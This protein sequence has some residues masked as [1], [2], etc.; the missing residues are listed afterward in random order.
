VNRPNSLRARTAVF[1]AA[2]F[3][4]LLSLFALGSYFAIEHALLSRADNEARDQ[5]QAIL[6]TLEHIPATDTAQIVAQ[7]RSIGEARLELAIYA[8]SGDS[9]RLVWSDHMIPLLSL[10]DQSELLKGQSN[11]INIKRE[12]RTY[13]ALS[14]STG[15]HVAIATLDLE[16]IR[17][18]E[19]A[20]LRTF[21]VLLLIGIAG[22]AAL[23]YF[24]AGLSLAPI[25]LLIKGA[26]QLEVAGSS[27]V[28]AP[29]LPVPHHVTEVAVLANAVNRLIAERDS[30]ITKLKTFT[31][32]AAHEL[33]T[34]LTVLKG[35]LE[36]ELR[37]VS[38]E[39][40]S[41]LIYQSNLEEVER[42]IM[43]V[44]DLLL[45]ADLDQAATREAPIVDVSLALQRVLDRLHP[46]AEIKSVK[47]SAKS[48]PGLS[49]NAE[50][51]RLERMIYNLVHNAIA[52]SEAG[53]VVRVELRSRAGHP[54]LIIEDSGQGIAES[55]LPYIFDRFYRTERAR[56]RRYGGVGLGL[57]I[58]RSIADEYGF[59]IEINSALGE[60]TIVKVTL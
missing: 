22:S 54:N 46:L 17:E 26:R 53:G 21:V 29:L 14:V 32:D 8:R 51:E 49:T 56:N 4:L 3:T 11:P 43:I 36:V 60:G 52:Y 19:D 38:K 33:R 12:G 39:E 35:E 16:V 31:A 28:A 15:E 27:G 34:P 57:A 47:L 45:L 37:L 2:T 59:G 44:Q 23:G 41:Y 9:S 10:Q 42:L 1:I 18:A 6:L 48:E 7:H 58:V 13:R 24:V 40:P 30:S 50:P 5:M 25:R 20:V 55:D